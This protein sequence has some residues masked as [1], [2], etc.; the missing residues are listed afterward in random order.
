MIKR[1]LNA[2]DFVENKPKTGLRI[3]DGTGRRIITD[4]PPIDGGTLIYDGLGMEWTTTVTDTNIIQLGYDNEGLR[5]DNNN[6]VTIGDL[7]VAGSAEIP[8]QEGQMRYDTNNNLTYVF[9]GDTW[10]E[11]NWEP[12][13]KESLWSRFKTFIKNLLT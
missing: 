11:I 8:P 10:Q 12:V 9:V 2:W 7:V 1:D 3:V 13:K 6:Q 4:Y 5:I